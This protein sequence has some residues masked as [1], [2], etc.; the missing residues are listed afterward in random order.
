MPRVSRPTGRQLVEARRSYIVDRA[1]GRDAGRVSR[2]APD[3]LLIGRNA[4]RS[5]SVTIAGSPARAI[6]E[7][8]SLL[9][10]K[11]RALVVALCR[12]YAENPELFGCKVDAAKRPTL[13]AQALLDFG[14]E[15]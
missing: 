15:S 14:G 13:H 3:P 7:R 5:L 4:T 6:Q 12:L 10:V 1:P 2:P 11:P 9:G 8:A